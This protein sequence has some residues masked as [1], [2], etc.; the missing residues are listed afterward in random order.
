VQDQ[1]LPDVSPRVA[2]HADGSSYFLDTRRVYLTN[3]PLNSE[4]KR[5]PKTEAPNES[6]LKYIGEVSEQSLREHIDHPIIK[7][8][9]PFLSVHSV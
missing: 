1:G 9:S 7:K 2:H 6:I 5:M 3:K 8:A 4:L